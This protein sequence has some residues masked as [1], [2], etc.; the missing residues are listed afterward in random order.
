MTVNIE[1]R[2]RIVQEVWASVL[3][4]VFFKKDSR[5]SEWIHP[6]FKHW[7]EVSLTLLYSS[8]E[9][10]LTASKLTCTQTGTL[11]PSHL[12]EKH[13]FVCVTGLCPGP[14]RLE[15]SRVHNL[16]QDAATGWRDFC[17][18]AI[19]STHNDQVIQLNYLYLLPF[20]NI[21]D[22]TCTHKSFKE[23]HNSSISI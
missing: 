17:Q 2:Q 11:C 5:R 16:W 15:D 1:G 4:S 14:G 19:K 10:I 9:A 13:F 21:H 22:L 3:K 6:L 23:T 12:C 8:G 20:W 18:V 7:S